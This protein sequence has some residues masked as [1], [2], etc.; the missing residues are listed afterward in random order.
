MWPK[1]STQR[2]RIIRFLG[3]G[4]AVYIVAGCTST[5]P[6]ASPQRSGNSPQ[7]D[8]VA[9]RDLARQMVDRLGLDLGITDWS[10][11]E[12]GPPPRDPEVRTHNVR[13]QGWTFGVISDMGMV[14]GDIN[15]SEIEALA[16]SRPRRQAD[17]TRQEARQ[18]L[19]EIVH[20]V[21]WREGRDFVF[22][23]GD[24]PLDL[25]IL[26]A[27][28]R[29]LRPLLFWLNAPDRDG[30]EEDFPRARFTIDLVTGQVLGFFVR[31][32]DQPQTYESTAELVSVEFAA[33]KARSAVERAYAR[34]NRRLPA[35]WPSVAQVASTVRRFWGLNQ[36]DSSTHFDTESYPSALTKH[37]FTRTA[38]YR[39]T[40]A[41]A[42]VVIHAPTGRLISGAFFAKGE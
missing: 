1:F 13:I 9:S 41:G 36:V 8:L 32:V 11:P 34:M 22:E 14:K 27:D 3:L 38:N 20:R 39:F 30:F 42:Q 25:R 21:G 10:S 18:A 29:R 24:S 23:E 7:T 40:V 4:V 37:R 5:E 26:L 33:E 35:D 19:Q 31:T 6:A 17:M 28:G 2:T 15:Q 12:V 16:L